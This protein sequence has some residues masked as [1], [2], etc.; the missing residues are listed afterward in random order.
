MVASSAVIKITKISTENMMAGLAVYFILKSLNTQEE[1]WT[2]VTCQNSQITI[3]KCSHA[4]PLNHRGLACCPG[5]P[6]V[7]LGS[8]DIIGST[9]LGQVLPLYFPVS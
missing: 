8:C 3:E 9:S 6:F 7:Q 2:R 5:L 4:A 1:M